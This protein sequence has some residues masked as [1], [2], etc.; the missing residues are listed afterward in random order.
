MEMKIRL[1]VWT[2]TIL[3]MALI[4]FQNR[5]FYLREQ[6]LSLDLYIAEFGLPPLANVTQALLFF[7]AGIV[8]ACVSLYHERF[9]LRREIKNLDTA[10][11]SC[12]Q[13]VNSMKPGECSSHKNKLSNLMGKLK[14]KKA[15]RRQEIP[16]VDGAMTLPVRVQR[17]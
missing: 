6:T 12:A 17:S 4:I 13:Q 1:S 10:F 7:L 9:K 2:M 11:H 14:G 8:L 3:T 15:Q 5:E 16:A